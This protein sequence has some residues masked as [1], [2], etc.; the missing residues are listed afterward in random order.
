MEYMARIKA[1]L[2]HQLVNLRTYNLDPW[3]PAQ[4]MVGLQSTYGYDKSEMNKANEMLKTG[5]VPMDINA[6]PGLVEDM[7]DAEELDAEGRINALQSGDMCYFCKKPGHQK[8]DCRKFDE[9][10]RKNPNRKYGSDPCG[11]SPRPSFSC[12]NSRKEGHISWECRGEHRNQVSRG[13]GGSGGGQ[14]ADMAKSL[15]A[16]QEV[17]KKLVPEAGFPRELR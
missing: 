7:S 15:A 2:D 4:D 11:A 9:W 5:Q 1:V 6:M 12:Y 16:V 13:N 10:K 8:R 14:M 3:A 17:L